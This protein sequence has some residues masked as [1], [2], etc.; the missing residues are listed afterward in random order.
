[1]PDASRITPPVLPPEVRSGHDIQLTVRLDAGLPV[2]D[3]RSTSH[4]VEVRRD[5][6]R[7]AHV[8]LA[9]HDRI[10]NKTF[11][12]QY[13]VADALIRPAVLVHREPGA[14]HGYFLAMLNPQLEPSE[15]EV[16]PRE[17]YFVLDTSCSQSGLPI[18][19]S[20]AVTAEALRHLHPEDTFQI[21]NFD[22]RVTKFSEGAV[23][24]SPENVER[25]L[26]YVRTSGAAAAPTFGLRHRRPWC[27]RTTRRV[28]A[29]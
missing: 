19:K 8:R 9:A 17:L 24:A 15:K 22:T 12:L 4:D 26:A 23:P 13:R 18:E 2:H 10:P 27:R 5:G 20:K 16:V 6:E 21:L 14:D 11:T 29:W 3:V 7:R 25:A 1:M 28:C